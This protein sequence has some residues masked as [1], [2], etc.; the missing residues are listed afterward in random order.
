MVHGSGFLESGSYACRFATALETLAAQPGAPAT[1]VNETA[2]ACL[3]PS[4][5]RGSAMLFVLL[6][7]GVSLH[8]EQPFVFAD[9]SIVSIVPSRA[10]AGQSTQVPTP[11]RL[12]FLLPRNQRQRRTYCELCHTLK[13]VTHWSPHHEGP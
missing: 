6:P 5:D 9:V 3:A 11:E 4:H 7:G 12:F 8:F 2:L 10:N 1:W 13:P